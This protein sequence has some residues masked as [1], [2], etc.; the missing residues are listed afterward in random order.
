M[1]A[2]ELRIGSVT[3]RPATVLAPMAGLTDTLFRRFIR[4]LDEQGVRSGL[5]GGGCGL[6]MTEFTSSEGLS[7]DW[8]RPARRLGR[9]MRYLQ[10]T[11]EE[12]PISAQLFG[13][14]PA[15]LADAARIVQE[16]GFD[17][18]DLNAERRCAPHRCH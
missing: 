15:H 7:R 5:T 9:S 3:I 13:A 18:V 2:S 4:R 16:L 17:L 10:F 11:A 14:D 8:A 6:I 1:V 12:R